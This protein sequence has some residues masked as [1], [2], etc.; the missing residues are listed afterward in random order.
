MRILNIDVTCL[1]LDGGADWRGR[2]PTIVCCGKNFPGVGKAAAK[3]FITMT[4]IAGST[5]AGEVIPLHF[6]FLT[7][8][9]S[10]ETL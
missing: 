4:M 5:A 1:L 3:S 7:T 8:A 2:Q 9:K 6:Q 10:K